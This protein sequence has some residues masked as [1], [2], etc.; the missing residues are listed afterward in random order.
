MAD[1]S[2]YLG[3]ICGNRVNPMHSSVGGCEVHTLGILLGMVAWIIGMICYCWQDKGE[4]VAAPG[5]ITSGQIRC[6]G[7]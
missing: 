4:V 2:Y 7:G 6:R 5:W 1:V 3:D